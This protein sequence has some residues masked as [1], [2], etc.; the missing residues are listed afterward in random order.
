MAP[1]EEINLPTGPKLWLTVAT[2]CVTMFFKGL[3]RLSN[4]VTIMDE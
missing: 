3:V 4:V 1:E 2:L